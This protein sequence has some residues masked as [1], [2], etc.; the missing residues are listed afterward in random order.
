MINKYNSIV[1]AAS[2]T[3][4]L[5]VIA[6]F[7]SVL[8]LTNARTPAEPTRTDPLVDTENPNTPDRAISLNSLREAS[9]QE[10]IA[11]HKKELEKLGVPQ[12]GGI[13]VVETKYKIEHVTYIIRAMLEHA[14]KSRTQ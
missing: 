14:D 3:T 12:F 13:P 10:K 2:V 6:V 11:Y 8:S 1:L 5:S 7:F 4:L 9:K